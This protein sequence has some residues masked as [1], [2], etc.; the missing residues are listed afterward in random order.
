[1]H[2]SKLMKKLNLPRYHPKCILY[3]Y[4]I[5]RALIYVLLIQHMFP[6]Y[7]RKFRIVASY[8]GHSFSENRWH[9][10]LLLSHSTFANEPILISHSAGTK[11]ISLVFAHDFPHLWESPASSTA[12]DLVFLLYIPVLELQDVCIITRCLP[13]H[14]LLLDVRPPVAPM[15]PLWPC[16]SHRWLQCYP[17]DHAWATSGYNDTSMT[18]RQPPVAPMYL[19]DHAWATGGSNGTPVIIRELSVTPM[20]PLW[21]CMSHRWI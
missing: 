8:Y 20:V 15:V 19:Y 18:M 13:R 4:S 7:L 21:P 17:C 11:L 16:V 10:R 12:S 1:M 3:P 2:D 5:K 9:G 6:A 14:W